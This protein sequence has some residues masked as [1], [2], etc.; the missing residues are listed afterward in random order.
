MSTPATDTGFRSHREDFAEVL[1]PDPR[2]EG[3][4]AVDAHEGPVYVAEEDALYF[5]TLRANR[6]AIKRLGLEDGIVTVVRADANT[7][8]GMALDRDGRLVVCEQGTLST[9]ARIARLSRATG[10]DET[11]V[12]SFDGLPLNSPNDVVVRS[13]GTIWFTD[14]SYGHLQGFRPEPVLPDAVYRYDPATDTIARVADG[15]DKPNGLAFSL[16]E[17]L[18]Y[19]SDNGR[20]H[21]LLVFA[22]DSDR[23]LRDRRVLAV[24]T[25]EHPDGLAVDT[26]GRIYTS[27]A[28]G[29]RVLSPGGELLGEIVLPGAVNFTF[30][31]RGGS[32]LFVTTDTSIWAAT[33]AAK[34]A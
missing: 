19:V 17:R 16:D 27:A 11:V 21:H 4:A 10:A 18:L 7:A 24:G 8:N 23:T 6:V 30:G 20:P 29:V 13:D 28:G 26:R 32:T 5:T 2:L 1:G 33:I 34:G 14:P 22:V 31:G 12:D 3:I 9:P 25:P 15:F